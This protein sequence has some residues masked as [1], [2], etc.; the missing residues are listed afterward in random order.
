[1]PPSRSKTLISEA[2]HPHNIITPAKKGWI[3]GQA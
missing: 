3:K 2:I 1:M